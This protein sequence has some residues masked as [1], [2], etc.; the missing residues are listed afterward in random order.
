MIRSALAW[1][2]LTTAACGGGWA[3]ADAASARDAANLELQ[4]ESLVGDGDT[5]TASQVRALERA[6][7]CSNASMLARH[8]GTMPDGGPRCQ[9]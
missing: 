6:A 4:V 3:D 7:Y 2:I 9:P 1:V 8:G 5:C